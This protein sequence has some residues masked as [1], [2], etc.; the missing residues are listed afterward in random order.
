MSVTNPEIAQPVISIGAHFFR[1]PG[2]KL[3]IVAL[4]SEVTN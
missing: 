1:L 3:L 2:E 4:L